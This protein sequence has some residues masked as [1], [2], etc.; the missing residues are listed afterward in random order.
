M[1]SKTIHSIIYSLFFQ[2]IQ[3]FF[4]QFSLFQTIQFVY[5][6]ILNMDV[7]L[8]EKI[9]AK[10]HENIRVFYYIKII[11]HSYDFFCVMNN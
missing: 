6:R 3:F 1:D 7:V 11:I 9:K 5:E 10:F 4:R 8:D 2:T